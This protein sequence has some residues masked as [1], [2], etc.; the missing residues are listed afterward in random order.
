M[1]QDWL[2][3]HSCASLTNMPWSFSGLR[4]RPQ[5]SDG[6]SA[7]VHA[8]WQFSS[9]QPPARLSSLHPWPLWQDCLAQLT[10][11]SSSEV[12]RHWRN[13]PSAEL[14]SSTRLGP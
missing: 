2:S 11:T 3:H 9:S 10:A 13:L 8:Q 1:R 4:L 7:V 5:V 6:C 14:Y 12:A